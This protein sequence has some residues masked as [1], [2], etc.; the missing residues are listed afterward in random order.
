VDA[1][2]VIKAIGGRLR[3]AFGLNVPVVAVAPATL[4]RFET[5]SR[6]FVIEP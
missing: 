1:A 5:K 4:P 6:R 3:Q 2:A